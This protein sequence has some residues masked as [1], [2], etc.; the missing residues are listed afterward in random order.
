LGASGPSHL[1]IG[2]PAP[3]GSYASANGSIAG[4]AP[5]NPFTAGTATF[6]IN[7]PTLTPGTTVVSAVFFFSTTQ[8]VSVVGTCGGIVP[9]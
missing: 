8:G 9:A 5:H 1:L 3:S 2:D 6:L 4:N 7:A